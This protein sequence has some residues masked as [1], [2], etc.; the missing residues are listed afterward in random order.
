MTL[1]NNTTKDEVKKYF[2]KISFD[3]QQID[4]IKSSEVVSSDFNGNRYAGVVDASSI[5]VKDNHLNLY[6]WYDNEFGYSCQVVRLLQRI[7]G[8]VHPKL[9]TLEKIENYINDKKEE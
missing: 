6:V 8:I 4:Y 5:Y 1:K 7:A 3:S 9:P 2:Q